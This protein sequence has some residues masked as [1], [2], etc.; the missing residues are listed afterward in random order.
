MAADP[1]KDIVKPTTTMNAGPSAFL[2]APEEVNPKVVGPLCILYE[3]IDAECTYWMD[4]RPGRVTAHLVNNWNM[5]LSIVIRFVREDQWKAAF[6]MWK[7][8]T[9]TELRKCY[10]RRERSKLNAALRAWTAAMKAMER[11]ITT[12]IKNNNEQQ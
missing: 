9:I 4:K 6:F 11:Y 1:V 8:L 12:K 7:Q 2:A 10:R 3:V 5:K